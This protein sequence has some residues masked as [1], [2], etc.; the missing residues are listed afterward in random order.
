MFNNMLND[1]QSS[2]NFCPKCGNAKQTLIDKAFVKNNGKC[3]D[4]QSIEEVYALPSMRN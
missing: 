4:C 1:I 3:I 2:I